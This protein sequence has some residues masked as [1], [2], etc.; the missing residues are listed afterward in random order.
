M[1]AC[2]RLRA[3]CVMPRIPFTT[4]ASSYSSLILFSVKIVML[5]PGSKPHSSEQGTSS[6]RCRKYGVP[7]GRMHESHPFGVSS[8]SRYIFLVI[9]RVNVV[10]RG[11][12][13]RLQV[14][15]GVTA[16]VCPLPWRVT[17]LLRGIPPRRGP[18]PVREPVASVTQSWLGSGQLIVVMIRL[19]Y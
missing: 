8:T 16:D 15:T 4:S 12:S 14:L 5:F 2:C 18:Q 9:R 10:E 17:S 13:R 19:V 1:I 3:I 6:W 11:F 7:S